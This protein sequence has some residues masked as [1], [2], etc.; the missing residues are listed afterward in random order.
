M[1]ETVGV[2]ARPCA[3]AARSADPWISMSR[4]YETM[5]TFV[6]GHGGRDHVR[7]RCPANVQ[8]PKS[9]KSAK[10]HVGVGCHHALPLAI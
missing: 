5:H 4:E 1:D 8:A 10:T 2:W 6:S 9:S 3:L 7:I